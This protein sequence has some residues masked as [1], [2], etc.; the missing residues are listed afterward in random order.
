MTLKVSF[1]LKKRLCQKTED[2]A[3]YSNIEKVS[4]ESDLLMKQSKMASDLEKQINDFAVNVCCS[5]EYLYH[6]KAVTKIKL[7]DN[8]GGTIWSRLRDYIS[9]SESDQC[10]MEMLLYICHSGKL[11]IK[12]ILYLIVVY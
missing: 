2:M 3:T 9:A 4:L 7:S 8:L 1:L 6:K 12:K 10:N 5:C 11:K